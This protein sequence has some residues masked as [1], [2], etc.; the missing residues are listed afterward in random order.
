ML[1]EENSNCMGRGGRRSFP[2]LT[3]EQLIPGSLRADLIFLSAG[4]RQQFREKRVLVCIC[5]CLA[6]VRLLGW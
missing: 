3:L 2:F 6:C 4:E 5:L 1:K